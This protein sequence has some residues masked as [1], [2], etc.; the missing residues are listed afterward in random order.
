MQ[1]HGGPHRAG[2]HAHTGTG[3]HDVIFSDSWLLCHVCPWSMQTHG[4][5]HRAGAH[6]HTGIGRHDVIFSD[7]WLLCH[8]CLWS[9][10]THGGPH[11]AG[12]HAHTGTGHDRCNPWIA[13]AEGE[14]G[15]E[16][17]RP[18]LLLYG[19]RGV[20]KKHVAPNL[21]MFSPSMEYSQNRH[22]AQ[23]PWKVLFS[24]HGARDFV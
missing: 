3:R 22:R 20:A 4:G 16:K 1:T 17:V 21:A 11:R 5:P 12:A 10:Q 19:S 6:A 18:L 2:A 15:E 23:R 13:S 7:S 9:I 14:G 8:V 24:Q